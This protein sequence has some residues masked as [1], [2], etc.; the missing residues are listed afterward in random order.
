MKNNMLKKLPTTIQVKI[1]PSRDG[2][3]LVDLP[4]YGVCTEAHSIREVGFMVNDLIYTLFDVPKEFQSKIY[5]STAKEETREIEGVRLPSRLEIL[6]TKDIFN[7][8]NG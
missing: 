3:I 1:Q 8:I 4:E 6:A 5:Y 2:V 7:L